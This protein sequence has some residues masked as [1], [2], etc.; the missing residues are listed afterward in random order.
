[1]SSSIPEAVR[2]PARLEAVEATGLPGDATAPSFE[3]LVKLA[4]QLLDAPLGFFTVVDAERSWYVASS[5]IPAELRSGAVEASFCK[6]VIASGEPLVVNDATAD[7]RT[8]TNPAIDEMGVRAWAGFP[9]RDPSGEVLGSFCVVDTEEHL[10]TARDQSVLGSL[11]AAAEDE[12][13]HLLAR[14]ATDAARREM[15]EL[16][17]RQ[18]DLLGL[19]QASLIPP[20]FPPTPGLDV[21]VRYEPVNAISGMGGDWYDVIDVGGGR[22]GLVVADVS[23]HDAPAVAV[24]AQL[25]PALH[26]FARHSTGP[27]QVH[28]QLH[29]LMLD[30]RIDRFLTCFYGIWDPTDRTLTYQAAGHPPPLL[31]RPDGTSELCE[32]GR[33]SFL[34]VVGLAPTQDQHT[35]TLA[36]G[37]SLAV[38]TDGLF[39]V[40][41]RDF[42]DGLAAVAATG[43]AL[44]AP[45]AGELADRL[46]G[47][48][49]PPGGWLDDVALLVA[50]AT[51]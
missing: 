33:T 18:R 13:A 4:A 45:T 20:D 9:V 32:Q 12:V 14:R 5:G 39:E 17:T 21:A 29:D 28:G 10:W 46:V 22:I 8:A 26:A 43:A 38:F 44:E 41:G 37:A 6:Y 7:E 36:V 34:G 35:V 25:R 19:L 49:C 40:P 31:F 11:A 30:L 27:A 42:D 50:T 24:M 2:R 1:M 16:R 3:R 51:R 15:D 47:A 23:G 48:G